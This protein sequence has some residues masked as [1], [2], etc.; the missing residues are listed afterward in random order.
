[1]TVSPLR[2]MQLASGDLWAGAE[3]QLFHLCRHLAAD[4]SLRLSVVLLNE[5]ELA[6]RLRTAG[7]EIQVLDE[8]RLGFRQLAS[9][10]LQIARRERPDVI[11]THRTKENLLGALAAL[12]VGARSMRTVHGSLE[13]DPAA[14]PSLRRRVSTTL[15]ATLVAR[16]QHCMVAVSAPLQRELAQRTWTRRIELVHNGIDSR[17]VAELAAAPVPL[18]PRASRAVCIVGRL[19]PVKRVDVF[20][21]AAAALRRDHADVEFYIIG[22]GPLRESLQQLARELG[23]AD[24]C[25][26]TGHLDNCL[27]LLRQMSAL[28]I[29]SDHEG[30]PM[31]ALE[32]LALGV[33]LVSHAVGGLPDLLRAASRSTLVA[34]QDPAEFARQT[35]RVLGASSRTAAVPGE[36][37]A[38]Y[39]IEYSAHRYLDIYRSLAEG[40]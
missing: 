25:T 14:R 3:S 30:T 18:Q 6:S 10:L 26:F 17:H 27:P 31:T 32:A 37:P 23:I 15:D 38:E 12:R 36:L 21:R 7:V 39:H 33:P 24:A 20:L 13:H 35:A 16:L 22:D 40:S 11:H 34:T 19:V 2:V 1:V 29:T 4:A 8:T 28:L 5:G 9:A